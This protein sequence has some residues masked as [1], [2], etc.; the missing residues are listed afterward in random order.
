MRTFWLTG[1]KTNQLK[2]SVATTK[3]NQDLAQTTG[4][5]TGKEPKKPFDLIETLPPSAIPN[6]DEDD[7]Q[8]A[9]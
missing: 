7:E 1:N 3:S 8:Q 5:S 6:N 9:S 4:G 2:T